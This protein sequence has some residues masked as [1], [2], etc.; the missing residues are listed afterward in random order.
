VPG[1]GVRDAID[2]CQSRRKAIEALEGVSL[3]DV[4]PL[5]SLTVESSCGDGGFADFV[6]LLIVLSRAGLSSRGARGC[7]ALVGLLVAKVPSSA[8]DERQSNGQ[9]TQRQ[10]S[11]NGI[12]SC[13]FV[14]ANIP[15]KCLDAV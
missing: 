12:D 3:P 15:F 1:W 9:A 8:D 11:S 7:M 10:T 14:S 13:G 5:N 4:I 6:R 2:K